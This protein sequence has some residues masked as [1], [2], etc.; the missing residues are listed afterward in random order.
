M[1]RRWMKYRR[2]EHIGA[3]NVPVLLIHGKDDTV[4]PYEQS[5]IMVDALKKGRQT[6]RVCDLEARRS[7]A[8]HGRHPFA[9]VAGDS[10]FP[11]APIIQRTKLLRFAKLYERC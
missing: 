7:L 4:V 6:G 5:E 1:R 2:F 3:V 10:R 11:C 8:F 9:D